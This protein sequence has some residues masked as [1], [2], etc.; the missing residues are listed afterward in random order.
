MV[1]EEVAISVCHLHFHRVVRDDVAATAIIVKDRV[2]SL[3][4]A[5]ASGD[6]PGPAIKLIV[7]VLVLVR[8]SNLLNSNPLIVLDL[9]VVRD[10]VVAT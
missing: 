4:S 5:Q 10:A 3:L 6:P 1:S 9:D 8:A 2:R 7:V